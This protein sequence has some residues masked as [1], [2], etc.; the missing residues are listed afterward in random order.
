MTVG[1]IKGDLH[2]VEV[3]RFSLGRGLISFDLGDTVVS[4]GVIGFFLIRRF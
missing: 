3:G 4:L 1:I 2:P